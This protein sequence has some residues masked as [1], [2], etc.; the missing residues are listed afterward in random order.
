MSEYAAPALSEPTL[1]FDERVRREIER[2]G[3][4]RPKGYDVSWHANPKVELHQ[5]WTVASH[6]AMAIDLDA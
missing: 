6:E 5:F 1:T 2:N 4:T 3:I